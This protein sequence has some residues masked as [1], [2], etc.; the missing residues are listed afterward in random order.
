MEMLVNKG[1]KVVLLTLCDRG[2]LH[3]YA[4]AKGVI[5]EWIPET[6]LSGKFSFYRANFKK[7]KK[8]LYQYRIDVVIAHQQVTALIA[9][10]LRKTKKFPLVYFRHNSD[11]D[12]QLNYIKAKWYNKLINALTPVKV[13]P[14]SVV[15]AFW[16]KKEGVSAKQIT[17]IN[18]GYNFSQYEQPVPSKAEEIRKE[19]SASLLILS[20]ARLVPS[21]RHE[22]M[23]AIVKRLAEN[24]VDCKLICL[25]TGSHEKE[26]KQRIASLNMQNHIFLLGR[27]ENVFDYIAAC[28]VFMHL[29]STEASN[30][31][32]K[33][34]GL[35]KKPVIVCKGVGDFDDYIVNGQNGF[36]LDKEKPEGDAFHV[37]MSMT[38]NEIN[39]EVT[40]QRL[41]ETITAE[42]NINKVAPKYEEL[43]NQLVKN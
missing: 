10:L 22:L 21:K 11:E 28:D 33:E 30:S 32:V 39:S 40:G 18:Y 15:E 5:T 9:G 41:F 2:Y 29:S 25:G 35:C 26:L 24:G 31:A 43:L 14:S 4:E 12:Y 23:F 34:V 19:F 37:L 36:L 13:A 8:V 27:R 6:E 38:R 7:L 16:I 3:E 1:H 20:I 42:F 17:R